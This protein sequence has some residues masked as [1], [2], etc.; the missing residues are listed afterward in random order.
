MKASQFKLSW[1]FEVST[2][3]T[4]TIS[5]G[6]VLRVWTLFGKNE[7]K[8]FKTEGILT[9]I[10]SDYLQMKIGNSTTISIKLSD[11]DSIELIDNEA[12]KENGGLND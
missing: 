12:D 11:I 8:T 10:Q 1:I 5:K 3:I 2:G 4:M 7:V 6:A 9:N